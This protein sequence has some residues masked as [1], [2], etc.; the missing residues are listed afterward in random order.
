MVNRIDQFTVRRSHFFLE[1]DK[2]SLLGQPLVV[3]LLARHWRHFEQEVEYHVKNI[4]YFSTKASCSSI[5]NLPTG[6]LSLRW[7]V[8]L[9]KYS[10]YIVPTKNRGELDADCLGH[11]KMHRHH[12]PLRRQVDFV[13]TAEFAGCKKISLPL[14]TTITLRKISRVSS[15]IAVGLVNLQ[16]D[17]TRGCVAC[18]IGAFV[19]D[20]VIELENPLYI[21]GSQSLATQ[22]YNDMQEQLYHCRRC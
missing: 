6:V 9:T 7:D 10:G 15:C 4:V 11:Y 18:R 5:T 12:R 13:V 8:V 14:I 17:K 21:A 2:V 20:I 22:L 16:G 19:T 1:H 3:E